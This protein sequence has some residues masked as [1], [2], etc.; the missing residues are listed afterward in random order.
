[1]V[2]ASEASTPL[3]KTLWGGL[4]LSGAW[5]GGL[6]PQKAAEDS[7]AIVSGGG[8]RQRVCT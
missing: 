1:M 2:E 5:D 3:W 4:D 8:W 7:F 6:E